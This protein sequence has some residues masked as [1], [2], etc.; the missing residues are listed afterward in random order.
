MPLRACAAIP[1]RRP[2]ADHRRRGMALVSVLFILVGLLAL[3]ATLFLSWFLDAQAASNV[4]AGDDAL[5][6]AEAGIQHLWALLKPATD[7]A[8]ELAWP[9]GAAPFGSPAGFPEPPRTYR[10][11]VAGLAGG[12]LRALSEGTSHRGARRTVE[13]IFVRDPR[14]RP[15]A[16]LTI[17]ATASPTDLS[18][19]I[20]VSADESAGDL[21]AYGAETLGAAEAFR[22]ARGD[23]TQVA[24]VGASGLGDAVDR[25]RETTTLTLDGPQESGS[26]GSA[27]EPLVVRFTG[28]AEISGTIMVSGIVLAEAPLRV[29]GRLEIDGLLVAPQGIDVE[30]ELAIAGAAWIAG[31]VRVTAPGELAARYSG[32]ALDR[33][34]QAAPGVLPRGAILGAWREVW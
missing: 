13:A 22:N 32:E 33:S 21:P 34:D 30:G 17:A 7:F 31:E 11:R 29:R 10:V 3:T 12:R 25:L 23:G 4:S 18:G 16:A 5:Y 26:F 1:S 19:A 28:V 2:S 9:D 6:V 20:D 24:I 27:E 15:P 14:F 8:R